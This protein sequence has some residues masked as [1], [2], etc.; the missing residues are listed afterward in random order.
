MFLTGNCRVLTLYALYQIEAS[1]LIEVEYM[2][3]QDG[4]IA[5]LVKPSG[6]WLALA[7]NSSSLL[8]VAFKDA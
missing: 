4:A 8:S 3:L 7:V 5:S 6:N 2:D 1:K